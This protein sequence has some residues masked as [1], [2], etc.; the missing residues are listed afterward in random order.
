MPT[1]DYSCNECG[2]TFEKFQSMS[3]TPVKICPLCHGSVRRLVSGGTGII[4][5]GS[6]YYFTDYKKKKTSSND[7]TEPKTES[8]NKVKKEK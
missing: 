5:K 1:Y 2:H 4:F 6:G 8:K 7:N 3:D